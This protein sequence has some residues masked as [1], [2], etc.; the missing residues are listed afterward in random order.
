MVCVIYF[1]FRDIYSFVFDAWIEF[2]DATINLIQ[3][4][5]LIYSILQR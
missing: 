1:S 5:N 4:F 2:N 3:R